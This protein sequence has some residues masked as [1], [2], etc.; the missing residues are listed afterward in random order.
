MIPVAL[1]IAGSDS[2]AGAGI[3]ADLK[4]FAA[5]GVYGTTAIT[6]IT[7]QNTIG[8]D[9][10][11]TLSPEIVYGQIKSVSND[12]QIAAV[13]TG[14]LANSEIILSVARAITDFKLT[15]LVVD[16]VM[17]SK[18]GHRLLAPEAEAAMR[19]VLLPLATLITPNLPEAEVLTGMK[20]TSQVE[21]REAAQKLFALGARNVLMK[22]GHLETTDATDILYDGKTFMEISA[23]RVATNSTHGTGCTL[24]AAIAA[25][26]ALGETVEEACRKAKIYLTGA[27]QHAQPLGHG[28]GPVNHFWSLRN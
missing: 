14:M 23:P 12:L 27:L 15:N 1:S 2:S 21:M 9:A 7:A 26:L 6:A 13:K 8:V 4:A 17:V 25:H 18:S 22:G 5:C 24:S 19:Q 28:H 20:V 10:V 16:T 3:Q 11:E